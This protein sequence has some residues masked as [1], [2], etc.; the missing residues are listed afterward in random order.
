[1]QNMTVS[2][3]FRKLLRYS[4]RAPVLRS[5]VPG[6]WYLKNEFKIHLGKKLDLKNPQTFNEKLQWLKLYDHN[7]LYTTLVDKYKVKEYVAEKIGEQYVVPL[8]GVWDRFDNIDFSKLPEQ[9]VLKCN[10][11]SG[12]VFVCRD[13]S[14]FDYTLAKKNLERSL[15]KDYFYFGREWAYKGVP[16]KII[17]ETYMEDDETKEL[18]DYKFF[19]FDGKVK[20]LFVASDRLVPNEEVKFD[21]FD[22]QYNQL[23]FRQGHPN[24]KILPA[25][26][27]NLDLMVELAETLSQL[28]PQV[29]VDLYEINSKVY[30]GEMTFYHFGG[31]TPFVP[32]E[33]DFTF[34]NWIT[35]P[36]KNVEFKST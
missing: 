5:I 27:K 23:N 31:L 21:F 20:A 34:G 15:K 24:S 22:P 7:P 6:E 32:E 17:A 30:F 29:R 19:C 12:N 8:L 35:L 2:V 3:F 33:W 9:F 36:S 28:I 13:R 18:R 10:H 16:R 25:K 4:C 1:M 26:P 11:D 14:C